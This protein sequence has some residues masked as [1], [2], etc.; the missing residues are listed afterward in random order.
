MPVLSM[1]VNVGAETRSTGRA[2]PVPLRVPMSAV[3][4]AASLA[5]V[6]RASTA[7]RV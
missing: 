7:V 4:T 3:L 2:T 1:A 5:R 6:T